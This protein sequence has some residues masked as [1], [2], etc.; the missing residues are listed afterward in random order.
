VLEQGQSLYA[1]NATPAVL[2][3]GTT[4]AWRTL[5]EG[6]TGVDVAQLNADLVALGYATSAQLNPGS[7]YFG[8]ATAAAVERLQAALGAPRTGTLTFGQ[9]VF[10][11]SA[12]RITAVNATIGTDAQPG[13]P[14][15]TATST[16]R[17]VTATVAASQVAR[18][19]AGDRATLTLP[20]GRT[21]PAVVAYVGTVATTP[22]GGASGS[23]SPPTVEIDLTPADHAATGTV[24][25]V[26]ITA[27]VT[28]A[29]VRAALAVPVVALTAEPDGRAAV[30][31]LGL[32]GLTHL[33]PVTL[34]LF[35]DANGLV[36]V[37]GPGLA[38]GQQVVLP[39]QSQSV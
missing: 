25:Q 31:V 24:D 7:D 34:G 32:D 20:D 19:T 21:T 8:T 26:P 37:S 6:T 12:A 39:D 29:T 17:Q 22:S 11:P 9:V 28:T 38:A 27:S 35:D 30:L 13:R 4:P 3:F 5:S 14:V 18:V 23:S 16:T 2:L 1:V 10:L 33:L 15:L 36:Q